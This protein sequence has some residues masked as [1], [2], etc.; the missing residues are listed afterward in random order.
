MLPYYTSDE[1]PQKVLRVPLPKSQALILQNETLSCE[2]VRVRPL[3]MEDAETKVHD[4][5]LDV[6]RKRN[7]RVNN[8]EVKPLSSGG[9]NYTSALFA[10]TARADTG[11]DLSIFAKVALVG[12]KMRQVMDADTMFATEGIVYTELVVYY[13]IIQTQHKIKIFDFP[14]MFACDLTRGSETLLLEDLTKLGFSA[15]SRHNSAEW[16]FAAAAISKLAAFHAL[17]FAFEKH[18]PEEFQRMADRFKYKEIERDEETMKEMWVKI[19]GNAVQVVKDE[20]KGRI[21]KHLAETK[22]EFPKFK[23]PINKTVLVHGDYRTSNL[24]FK[25]KT[26]YTGSPAADVLYFIFLGTNQEFRKNHYRPLLDH[27]Y[28]EL[29]A[30]VVKMG[31]DINEE[32]PREMFDSEIKETLPNAL[33]LS[34]F[35]LP[36]V[37][38]DEAAA[39]SMGGEADATQFAIAP[40][41]LFAERFSGLVDDCVEWGVL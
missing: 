1:T 34:S 37:T 14:E 6:L 10:A 35:I 25:E 3:T 33:R 31:V 7:F 39:P 15:P 18:K 24:L 19:I 30:A 41:Q 13:D 36:I 11:A 23:R 22:Q 28:Q 40:N 32:Y 29:A 20:Y 17:S 12:E 9:A 4:L 26:V 38:V 21:A 16:R 8:V 5:F 27:Y 2:N